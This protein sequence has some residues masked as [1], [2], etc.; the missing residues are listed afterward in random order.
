[1]RN[2]Y[3]QLN[4]TLLRKTNKQNKVNSVHPNGKKREE[5]ADEKVLCG[6]EGLPPLCLLLSLFI[7]PGN[8][9]STQPFIIKP[10]NYF[11]PQPF[12]IKPGNTFLPKHLLLNLATPPYQNIY[13]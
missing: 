11:S 2:N 1:M 7:K 4:Q 6:G 5:F 10:G 8:Y 12:I 9:F 3:T 13:Y